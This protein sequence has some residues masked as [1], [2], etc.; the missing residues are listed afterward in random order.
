LGELN[1]QSTDTVIH[2]SLAK[3]LRHRLLFQLLYFALVLAHDLHII[4]AWIIKNGCEIPYKCRV[5]MGK[6]S[7][8]MGEFSITGR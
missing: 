3:S 7:N 4:W 2:Y 6:S 8:E 1:P 5:S